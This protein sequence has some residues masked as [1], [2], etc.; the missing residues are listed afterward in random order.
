MHLSIDAHQP[1]PRSNSFLQHME[2]DDYTALIEKSKLVSLTLRSRIVKQD[3]TV[4]AVFFPITCMFSVVVTEGAKAQME[5]AVVGKE[6]VTGAMEALQQ[7]GAIGLNIVQLPGVAL[8]VGA[9]AFRTLVGTRPQLE[10]AVNAHMYS[11][12][13]QILYGASCNKR[14]TMEERCARWLLMTQDRARGDT[15]PLTKTFYPIC[16]GYEGQL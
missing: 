5:L 13:R 6:S 11:L 1:D 9:E 14:H 2:L 3:E 7:R 8:R 12:M 15:F 16:S 4:D 10:R